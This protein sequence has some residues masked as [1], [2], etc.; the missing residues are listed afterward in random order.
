MRRRK[1]LD[2][3]ECLEIADTCTFF[4]VRRASRVV[5]KIFDEALRPVGVRATQFSLLVG[6]GMVESA[7]VTRMADSLALDRTSLTRNLGPLE[8]S[9]LVE[10]FGGADGRERRVRLTERGAR[11][12][13]EGRALWQKPRES[14]AACGGKPRGRGRMRGFPPAREMPAPG[15]GGE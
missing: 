6:L 5:G 11:G 8:R 13:A 9:G 12:R 15:G 4:S 14:V 7:T 2:R 10:S 1:R 3:L